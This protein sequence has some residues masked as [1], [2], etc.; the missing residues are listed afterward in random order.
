MGRLDEGT[1]QGASEHVDFQ[2]VQSLLAAQAALKHAFETLTAHHVAEGEVGVFRQFLFAGFRHIAE[3]MGEGLP[4]RIVAARMGDH[5]QARPFVEL[6][7]DGGHLFEGHVGK[8]QDGVETAALASVLLVAGV[9][10]VEGHAGPGAHLR[11][12]GGDVR[13]VFAHEGEAVGRAVLGHQLAARVI[14]FAAR[15]ED[16]FVAQ[17]VLLRHAHIVRA[18]VNLKVPEPRAEQGEKQHDAALQQQK[19]AFRRLI[20]IVAGFYLHEVLPAAGRRP[21]TTPTA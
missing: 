6:G 2:P 13:A 16:A 8:E 11:E 18:A 7:L 19:S 5:A 15:G 10:A 1:A 9:D 21:P 14:D 4:F 20:F 17:A 12:G 3:D